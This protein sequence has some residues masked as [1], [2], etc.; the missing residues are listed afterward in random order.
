MFPKIEKD[1]MSITKFADSQH[2][3]SGKILAL[4]LILSSAVAVF[5]VC[6][7]Y[8]H[9]PS[10]AMVG[11]DSSAYY[12]WLR[13]MV[14]KGPLVSLKSDRPF[15]NLLMYSVRYVAASP[16]EAVIRMM[17]AVFAVCLNLVVFWFVRTGTKNDFAAL[18]SAL[19]TSFSF[20][21]TVGVFAYFMANWLALIEVF[22][23]LIF[24]LKGSEKRSWKYALVS[25]FMGMAVLL[26]HPYTWNIL[27]AILF[28]YFIWI[29]LRG[30]S[31][32]SEIL[33]L[34]FVL[35]ANL[36]FYVVYTLMPFGKGVSN[37]GTILFT[38]TSNIG[39]SNLLHLHDGLVSI[40][41]NWVGGI[42]ANPLLLI[43][44]IVGLFSMFDFRGRFNRMMLLWV[45][46]PS[47]TL[48]AVSPD[49]FYYRL[50]YLIPIQIQA[51]VGLCWILDRIDLVRYSVESIETLRMLKMSIVILTVLFLLNYSL[52]SVEEASVFML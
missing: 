27:M 20:Y 49:P 5:I 34:T 15:F 3:F 40:I 16:P 4:S 42:F 38:A 13:E 23:L 31:E 46:V 22:V 1:Q 28:F 11:A 17:P 7:P 24:L 30:K 32:K 52:R 21:A 14:Q 33:F 48:L 9:L 50:I 29:F 39:I 36:S 44:A 8:F 6:Y 35:I 45:M 43:L 10:S 26:T 41:K 2:K 47:L 51:A 12:G 18:L 25:V 19:L 37:S